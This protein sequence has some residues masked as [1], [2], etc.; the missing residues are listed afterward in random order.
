[1]FALWSRVYSQLED[2]CVLAL[3]GS[4]GSCLPVLRSA[5]DCV[6]IELALCQ[7]GFGVYIEWFAGAVSQDRD[8]AALAFDIGRTRAG[9]IYAD[10][11]ELG[12]LFRVLTDLSMPHFGTTAFLSGPESSLQK[13]SVAF[14]DRAF[15]YG[16][17]Q[18]VYGWMLRLA[19]AQTRALLECGVLE[20]GEEDASAARELLAATTTLLAD[21]ARCRVED[22]GRGFVF[23]NFRRTASGQPKRVVLG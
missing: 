7:D 16:W 15:H 5:C 17:A 18:L 19:A 6:A 13:I 10:D 14:A 2:A 3:Q 8:R 22:A 12:A 11:P 23:H 9:S 20:T 4:Y 21:P 1:M